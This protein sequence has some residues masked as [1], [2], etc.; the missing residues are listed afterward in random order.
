MSHSLI[1][2]Y[3][4]YAKHPVT[5]NGMSLS[6]GCYVRKDGSRVGCR[7]HEDIEAPDYFK[8]MV[9]KKEIKP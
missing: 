5:P 7:T 2:L 4:R 9:T 3:R 8:S 1:D 6:C